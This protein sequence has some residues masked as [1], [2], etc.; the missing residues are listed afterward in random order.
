VGEF[1]VLTVER[2]DSIRMAP[3]A[4]SSASPGSL[5]TGLAEAG[6]AFAEPLAEGGPGCCGIDDRPEM[7]LAELG[8]GLMVCVVIAPPN[9]ADPWANFRL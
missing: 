9:R 2:P 3:R 6:S 1:L 8:L 4:N 5:V 7:K